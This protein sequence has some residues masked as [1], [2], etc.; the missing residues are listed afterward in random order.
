MEFLIESALLTHGLFSLSNEELLD[1]W[2]FP[3]A[4]IVWVEHGVIQEGPMD[5]FVGFRSRAQKAMRIDAFMLDSALEQGC[6][7]ALT[8]SGTMEV[9][10]RRGIPFAVTCG[11]GG[12]GDIRGEELCPDLPALSTLPVVLISTGPKDMLDRK[13]TIDWL[14]AHGVR[15]VGAEEAVS[16]G[17]LFVGEQIPLDGTVGERMPQQENGER[18]FQPPL[19][20]LQEIPISKRITDS[21]ILAR[22]IAEGKRAEQEGRYYHPAANA[23]IDRRTAGASSRMQL[24]SLLENARLAERLSKC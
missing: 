22:A 21:S 14:K 24:R 3:E 23:E 6:S 9:C 2:T 4:P 15:V 19:L 1:T 10:R 18:A 8:A 13:G 11:M 5:A 7:G 20:I 17:Y 16:T 12:L